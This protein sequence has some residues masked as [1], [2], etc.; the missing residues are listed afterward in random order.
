MKGFFIAGLSQMK[1]L[2]AG[3]ALL[4]SFA[5]SAF[6]NGSGTC[7]A[8]AASITGMQ[9]RP[10]SAAG[11][12]PFVITS[13]MMGTTYTPGA[14]HMLAIVS[15]DSSTFTGL[16]LYG[17]TML[18]ARAGS[19]DKSDAFVGSPAT[20]C[21]GDLAATI[22][23]T[24]SGPVSENVLMIPW[25]APA[26]DVGPVT[27][28][29]IVLAGTRND[30]ANQ[31]FF[32]PP[33]LVLTAA[34]GA[35]GND[36]EINQ[37]IAGAWFDPGTPGQGFLIEIEPASQF[38]FMAWFTYEQ[39]P[40]KIGAQEHRWLTAQGNYSGNS[41][42]IPIFRTSGGIFDDPAG[43]TTEQAGTMV[44]NFEDCMSGTIE[45]DLVDAGLQGDIS[46]VRVIPGTEELCL[47]LSPD[48]MV[49]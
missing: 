39:A 11:T 8:T 18:G 37:G 19:F 31:T 34:A 32:F 1:W 17:E 36:F 44:V 47:S 23:H 16:L 26:T 22:S 5:A 49:E 2:L 21:P 40:A 48:A 10:R 14:V 42:E 12:G 13:D 7:E 9:G 38:I 45:Y 6:P 4:V 35:G 33:E 41:A 29:S 28:R 27:F 30:I 15:T 3:S 46:I 43:T 25:T 24:N 20:N